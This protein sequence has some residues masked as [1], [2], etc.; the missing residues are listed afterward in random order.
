MAEPEAEFAV[1]P[2]F[3]AV[4]RRDLLLAW[5]TRAEIA[6]P[7]IFFIMVASLFPLGIGAD[8]KLLARV[9]A[10]V[11]WAC[12]VLA[13]L[14]SLPRIFAQ[15]HADGTLEQMALSAYPLSAIAGGKLAAHW[16][17][18]G[19]PLSLTAPVIGLQF[20]MDAPTQG[21][22]VLSLLIGSPILSMIGAIA[23]ALTLG[24]RGQSLLIALL[25]LP[26]YV[27][28]VIF[29]AGAVESF[30][31]G[32]DHGA[33]LALLGAGTLAGLVATPFVVAAAIRIALD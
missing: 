10:G 4:L 7:V 2:G 31:A 6:Q 21:V 29:G 33:H 1:L 24:A 28:V 14:L 11:V 18:T 5:R 23:A 20:G 16:L 22:L 26:L 27:P 30:G 25:V 13:T 12:G 32:I 8:M 9:G 15:D 3:V 19:L 17:T